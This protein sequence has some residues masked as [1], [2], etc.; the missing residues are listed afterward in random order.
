MCELEDGY[1]QALTG[2]VLNR[3]VA[4]DIY[5]AKHFITPQEKLEEALIDIGYKS[6]GVI[7]S[8]ELSIRKDLDPGDIVKVGDEVEVF[9]EEARAKGAKL[10]CID[11][12]R[13]QTAE[14]CD[15][16]IAPTP[17]TDGFLAHAIAH[18]LLRDG[19]VDKE[20]I[21]KHVSGYE[22]YEWLV[23]N[24][25]PE[26]AQETCGVDAAVIEDFAHRFAAAR[27]VNVN[28]GGTC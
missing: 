7:P 13:T 5:P 9:L 20:F 28:A 24:Y 8:R 18:V 15:E 2:E 6:E 4:L 14:A 27:P 21:E 3:H 19:L 12:L 17:G 23:R 22:D 1:F 10:V 26:K 11:P 16:H 25:T